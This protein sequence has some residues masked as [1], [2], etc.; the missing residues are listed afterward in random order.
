MFGFMDLGFLVGGGFVNREHGLIM[1]I[2]GELRVGLGR[3]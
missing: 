2:S 1:E 3:R